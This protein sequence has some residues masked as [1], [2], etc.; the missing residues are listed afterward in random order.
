VAQLARGVVGGGI[1]GHRPSIEHDG[2]ARSDIAAATT[3]AP[4]A[5]TVEGP[6][7]GDT[8]SALAPDVPLHLAVALDGTGFHPASWRDPSARPREIFG[9]PYWADLARTA[10]RGV[11]D[12][13]T[14]EDGFGVQSSRR[15]APDDRTDQV[16]GRLDALLIASLVAPLT[17]HI[18]L[19][20]TVVPTHTE[21]F[22]V[23]SAVA[24]LDYVSGGR[25]GWR[26]QLS[27]RPHEAAH[28]GRRSFP[29]GRPS[30]PAV[31]A[32]AEELFD[33]A[34]D[35]VEVVRRLWDS[36]ED[37]AVIRDVPTGRF[38][39]R[40]K[41]H[42]ID[43]EGR[44]FRVKG[45]SIVPRPPQGNPLVVALAH[46]RVPFEFAARAAD[47]VL[48]TPADRA[49]VD[50][51]VAE[52][53]DAERRVGRELPPLLVF[54]EV[55]VF[56]DDDADGAAERKERLDALDGR[57][58]RSDAPIFVGSPAAL[59]AQLV[60]WQAG[61]L[62]GF[63][64]RPGVIGHDLDAIV[65]GVV[66]ALQARGAFRSRYDDGLLRERLGLRRPDS[67]YADAGGPR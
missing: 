18:G 42:Y 62:D 49:D 45:P 32:A 63:R 58:L 47:V 22:H 52:V 2:R 56:L 30:D 53:R 31:A 14:I 57:A 8:L 27:T 1:H 35:A 10:E 34:A 13:L 44:F 15:A 41:L 12:F 33:E 38:V 36:W 48:V 29:D 6:E 11:L 19:V 40:D 9:A 28:V 16:R 51:W 66:P 54:G 39:D 4:R 17:Q 5:G 55:V 67:R 24:T 60:E 23:A 59:A 3:T 37:D 46:S 65:D 61:G 26:P 64:L 21:P 43:F 25:A 20:P 7:R 50:R